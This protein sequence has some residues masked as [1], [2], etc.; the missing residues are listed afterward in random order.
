MFVTVGSVVQVCDKPA[1]AAELAG[2]DG[3][4]TGVV[5]IG[6]KVNEVGAPV[7]GESQLEP[8]VVQPGEEAGAYAVDGNKRGIKRA[9][10]EGGST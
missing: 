4:L 9:F 7:G 8:F 10:S 1:E 3:T 2:E 6:R 5:D